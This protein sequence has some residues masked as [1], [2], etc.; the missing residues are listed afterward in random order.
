LIIDLDRI[1]IVVQSSAG[2][3]I[4]I[5]KQSKLKVVQNHYKISSLD[6][7]GLFLEGV[8]KIE[9]NTKAEYGGP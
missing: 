7:H 4:V 1:R 9:L 2:V 8:Y 6:C 5:M 3:F